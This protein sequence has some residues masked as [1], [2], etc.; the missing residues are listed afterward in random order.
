MSEVLVGYRLDL[1]DHFCDVVIHTFVYVY[2]CIFM[3][4]YV[5]QTYTHIHLHK[6]CIYTLHMK[7]VIDVFVCDSITLSILSEISK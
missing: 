6:M 4:I 1:Y 3:F 7:L 2:I 5:T